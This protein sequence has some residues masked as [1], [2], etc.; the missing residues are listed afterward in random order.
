MEVVMAPGGPGHFW[1]TGDHARARETALRDLAISRSFRGFH[2]QTTA[3]LRLGQIH[4]SLGDFPRAEEFLRQNV[5]SLEGELRLDRL[6]LPGLPS[7][8]SRTWLAWCL[9]ERGELAEATVHAEAGL[10]IAE[11]ASHARS[12][13]VATMGLGVVHLAAGRLEAA[14]STLER[15]LV[16]AQV[17]QI[18]TLFPFVAAP[19]GCG[20]ARLGR[21]AGAVAMLERA[22]AQAETLKLAAN[23]S[24][25]LVWLGQAHLLAGQPD[26]AREL[27]ERALVLA[28]TRGERAHEG[29]ALHLRATAA[30]S[31]A[32]G[33][34][35]YREGLAL[36][37][38]LG[39]EPLRAACRLGLAG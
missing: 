34:A 38:E 13:I 37:S 20:Y 22:L 8:S 14:V 4:H 6:G 26:R 32:D 39:M 16:L 23:Q 12:L 35:A 24:R 17:E 29:W 1:W 21:T 18:P 19:L 27:A 36:A 3:L 10:G 7:V 5:D 9:A 30:A 2:L 31:R 25:A 33:A 28:R 15:G 11:E